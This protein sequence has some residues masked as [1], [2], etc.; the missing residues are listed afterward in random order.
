MLSR[1]SMAPPKDFDSIGLLK[2]SPNDFTAQW[3]WK[4]IDL[5]QARYVVMEMKLAEVYD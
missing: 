4:T 3:N 5:V 2:S 1:D